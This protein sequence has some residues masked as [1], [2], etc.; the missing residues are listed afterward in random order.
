MEILKKVEWGY[1]F[2]CHSCKSELRAAASDLKFATVSCYDGSNDPVF[3]F[4]CASCGTDHNLSLKS[5]C[6]IP[7]HIR[8][9]AMSRYRKRLEMFS[10]EQ[11]PDAM[12]VA[13]QQFPDFP[14]CFKPTGKGSWYE[15]DE[16]KQEAFYEFDHQ[17]PEYKGDVDSRFATMRK[18]I[19]EGT[20][21]HEYGSCDS[22]EQFFAS[23]QLKMIERHAGKHIVV[24]EYLSKKSCPGWRFHK[25]GPYIG[26]KKH[27][28]HLGDCDGWDGVW[29]Y[30]VY[31]LRDKTQE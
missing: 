9:G 27:Y 8:D 25:N 7:N 17:W 21:F 13:L 11:L 29:T 3:Y 28:E 16:A 6:K 12:N 20:L 15:Y 10:I 30:H 5:E 22:P 14:G 2:T 26:E 4:V 18:R 31:R 24:F 23:D 19:E 1:E